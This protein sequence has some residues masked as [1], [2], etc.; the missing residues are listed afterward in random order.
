MENQDEILIDAPP[1]RVFDVITDF[2]R[3]PEFVPEN[4]DVVV[5]ERAD[6]TWTVR[7][8]VEMLMR[9]DY[10]LRIELDPP[11]AVTWALV[12]GKMLSSNCGEWRLEAL[13]G[14]RTKATY[15]LQLEFARSIS[16]AVQDRLVGNGLS[17]TLDL[18][19]KRAE[20]GLCS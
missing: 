17:R 18:F 6:R 16:P 8:E 5:L 12:E 19:K 2:E 4:Q 10:T 9:F 7:F 20:G 13:N 1:G 11:V 3:Y 14:D 15:R